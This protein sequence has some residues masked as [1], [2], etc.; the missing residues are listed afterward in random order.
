[1]PIEPADEI[2]RQRLAP[3]SVERHRPFLPAAP[4]DEGRPIG[5]LDGPFGD[6]HHERP[7][8]LPTGAMVARRG[9]FET[10]AEEETLD[11]FERHALDTGGPEANDDAAA[12]EDD[13]RSR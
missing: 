5:E 11:G 9:R 1:L 2:D 10:A 13:P 6:P 7:H 4:R 8:P 12:I 3:P